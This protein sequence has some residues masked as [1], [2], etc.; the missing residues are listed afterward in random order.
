[1]KKIQKGDAV[2]V[3]AGKFKWTQS[4]VVAISWE[5]VVVK[6][7]NTVKK[8]MKG[9]GFI[10]KD[11]PIHISN[12][13]LYDGKSKKASAVAIRKEKGKNVRFYKKSNEMV[14]KWE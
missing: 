1:M 6:G 12:V 9:K 14:T 2:I 3:N 13:S 11:A 5:R 4:T 10:E 8:A 7:V